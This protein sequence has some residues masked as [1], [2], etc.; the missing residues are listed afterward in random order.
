MPLSAG[1]QARLT[2]AGVNNGMPGWRI[3]ENARLLPPRPGSGAL[4]GDL[5][6]QALR[7]LMKSF[8]DYGR[9]HWTWTQ[10]A[11]VAAANGGLVRGM[12]SA[13]AC[14]SFN[15]NFKW[16]AENGLGIT[17]ITNGQENSQFLT[18]PGRMGIDSR[19]VGNV[20]TDRQGFPEL[21][22]F[23]FQR[24]NW[25]V[26][27]GTNYDVCFNQTFAT[28]TEIIWTK[29][30]RPD[31]QLLARSRLGVQDLYRLEKPLPAGDHLVNIQTQGPNGWPSWQIVRKE[32]V[33]ALR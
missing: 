25:V 33:E 27:G 26:H 22:S 4:F 31:P 8:Y 7:K 1:I 10:S 6:A 3:I 15:L 5:V 20:R 24:H 17:G 14:G 19:W 29:L 12:I 9:L 30:L 16:L 32:Q 21:K 23:K 13:V 2:A 28:H 18:L 11:G